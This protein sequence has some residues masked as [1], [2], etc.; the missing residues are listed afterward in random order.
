MSFNASPQS[1]AANLLPLLTLQK[2][3]ARR[4]VSRWLRWLLVIG[5]GAAAA[6]AISVRYRESAIQDLVASQETARPAREILH[7]CAELQ[8]D[9][10]A[11]NQRSTEERKLRSHF[12]PLPLLALL[13]DVSS[14][15]ESQVHAVSFDFQDKPGHPATVPGATKGGAGPA[16]KPSEN[17][18]LFR[19]R[20]RV[21]AAELVSEVLQQL[22]GSSYFADVSLDSAVE[23]DPTSNWFGFSVRCTF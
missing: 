22:K 4:Q 14:A 16:R 18:G 10:N 5:L 13:C 1:N 7:R 17:N 2:Q 9:I 12:S 11:L 3:Q 20:F 21:A 15:H 23:Q 8:R 6:L 19:V